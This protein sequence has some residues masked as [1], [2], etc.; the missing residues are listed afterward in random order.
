MA[1]RDSNIDPFNA[2]E[3]ILPWQDPDA[4]AYDDADEP[5]EPSRDDSSPTDSPSTTEE[6]PRRPRSRTKDRDRRRSTDAR[7][8]EA[9]RNGRS[10]AA[11][12][13]RG[14]T[15]LGGALKAFAIV[16]IIAM[17]LSIFSDVVSCSADFNDPENVAIENDHQAPEAHSDFEPTE[18]GAEARCIQLADARMN[19]LVLAGAPE[20]KA[21]STRIAT[22]FAQRIK[23]DFG[24]T[25]DQ[26]GIDPAFVAE[27]TIGSLA[28]AMNDAYAF[29]GAEDPYA[30]VY[31]D[32][33]ACSM[34]T[35]YYEFQSRLYDY[36]RE[37]DLS[38]LSIKQG[39]ELGEAQ[40]ADIA[41]ILKTTMAETDPR[42]SSMCVR[43]APHEDDW[44]I[45]E[46]E[47]ERYCGYV[48]GLPA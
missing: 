7:R 10:Q 43:L 20:H 18:D 25:P 11:S 39:H 30:S 16:W 41:D 1:R 29:P 45:D 44:A 15:I 27:W 4:E 37:Q 48:F 17:A 47:F 9:A 22:A 36:L 3:P 8:H 42:E 31:Y 12:R 40:K 13:G 38:L 32:V 23:D 28:Y 6:K 35:M 14:G 24:R 2:G 5:H 26:L 19:N 34:M 33:E 21:V 46:T